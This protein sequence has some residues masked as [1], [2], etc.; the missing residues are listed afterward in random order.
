MLLPA[1]TSSAL[2]SPSAK[3]PGMAGESPRAIMPGLPAVM[4]TAS[5]NL[6]TPAQAV[7]AVPHDQSPV[8]GSRPIRDPRSPTNILAPSQTPPTIPVSVSA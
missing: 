2:A 1:P 5:P 8:V 7:P 4:A 6:P 3:M